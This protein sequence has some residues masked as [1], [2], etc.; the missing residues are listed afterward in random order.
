MGQN[1]YLGEN[2]HDYMDGSGKHFINVDFETGCQESKIFI[3]M[4]FLE[5][6]GI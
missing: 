6:V 4:T 2:V 1:K 3:L 5:I